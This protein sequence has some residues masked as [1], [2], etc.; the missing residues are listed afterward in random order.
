MKADTV[1][2]I[3]MKQ[4]QRQ[5]KQGFTLIEVMVS[6]LILA[7]VLIG[8]AHLMMQ[9]SITVKQQQLKREAIISAGTVMESFWG[10]AY[11]D[12]EDLDG[13]TRNLSIYVT[14]VALDVDVTVD[15]VTDAEGMDC[16][17]ITAAA[18]RA[19]HVEEVRVTGRRYRQGL[20]Q[21]AVNIN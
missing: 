21:A 9:T 7:V 2:I 1:D 16:I 15:A 20:S 4:G 8:A 3:V 19:Q 5:N 13:S 11:D 10:M 14:G 12:L 17:E 6:A 18:Y